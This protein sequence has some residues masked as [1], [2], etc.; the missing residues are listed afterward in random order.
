LSTSQDVEDKSISSLVH[1]ALLSSVRL[2]TLPKSVIDIFVTVIECDGIESC[3]AAATVAASTSLAKAGVEMLGLVVSCA[4]VSC[5]YYPI[6]V[7]PHA[8][9]QAVVGEDVWLDPNEEE[10][11]MASGMLLYA[12]MPALGVATSVWQTGRVLPAQA[13]SVSERRFYA[14]STD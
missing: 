14:E 2:D 8:N 9:Y 3:V 1:Q 7:I 12:C 6:P 4:G 11:R 13:L 5:H 10:A